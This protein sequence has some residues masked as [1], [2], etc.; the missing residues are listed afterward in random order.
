MYMSDLGPDDGGET[1][2]PKAFPPSVPASERIDEKE[3]IEQLRASPNGNVLEKGSWEEQLVRPWDVTFLI[4]HSKVQGSDKVFS[5]IFL[6]RLHHA[7]RDSRCDL[8]RPEPSY[9]ILS[10]RTAMLIQLPSMVLARFL[11]N[12]NTLRISG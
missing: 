2:F 8:I 3:A 9:S 6:Y 7:G 1:V 12:R 5:L 4:G 11:I 10:I